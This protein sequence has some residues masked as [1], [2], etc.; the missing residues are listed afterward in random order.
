MLLLGLHGRS[1]VMYIKDA[2]QELLDKAYKCNK[3]IADWLMYTCN[4]PI[5]SMAKNKYYFA[6]SK[7]LEDALQNLPIVLKIGKAKLRL[8]PSIAL[9]LKFYNL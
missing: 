6:H 8:M 3:G 1:I 4:F 9:P 5:L 7:E 2:A